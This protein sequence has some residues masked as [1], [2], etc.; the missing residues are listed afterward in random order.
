MLPDNTP[1]KEY[2]GNGV[3]TAFSFPYKFFSADHVTVY[4]KVISTGVVSTVPN[5]EYTVAGEGDDAGGT[6]TFTGAPTSDHFITLLLDAVPLAQEADY[7]PLEGFPADAHEAQQDKVIMIL[8]QMREEIK[9]CPKVDAG[10][11]ITGEGYLTTIQQAVED[12]QAAEVDAEAA[13][14]AA[15]VAQAAAE[16]A[17]GSVTLASQAE[18]EAGTDNV[19]Y[20]S[21]LRVAQ[22]IA[23]RLTKAIVNDLAYPVG[24]VV[25]FGVSTNPATL[26]GIGTWTAIAGRVIVGIDAG[27]TEFDTLDETGGAKTHTLQTTEIPSHT[28][29]TGAGVGGGYTA[30]TGTSDFALTGNTGA[31]G[32]GGSHNNL[33]PYIVKYVWQRTA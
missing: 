29:A 13:Q 30:N 28:H 15:E 33:Q 21:S 26:L 31:T 27:Q 23:V 9:R 32:G 2:T 7:V 8:Q 3:T 6:F 24:S 25:T 5:T 17:A 16:A 19:K 12:C 14:T 22:S 11:G 20:L 4:R 18:A 1:I 10:S